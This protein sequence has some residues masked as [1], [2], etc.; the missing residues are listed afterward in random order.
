MRTR[1]GSEDSSGRIHA[2]LQAQAQ[3]AGRQRRTTLKGISENQA[4]RR[5]LYKAFHCRRVFILYNDHLTAGLSSRQYG[6][7]HIMIQL[8]GLMA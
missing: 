6:R 3:I 8:R 7:H 2:A 5:H 1:G 4:R